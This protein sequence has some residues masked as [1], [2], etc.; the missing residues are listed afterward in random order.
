MASATGEGAP[1]GRILSPKEV[2]DRIPQQEPFRFIDEIIEID[3]DHCSASYRWREDAAF[4]RGHF[5]GDPVTPGV[6]LVEALAQASVVAMTA[7][8]ENR[9]NGKCTQTS[10]VRAS[11]VASTAVRARGEGGVSHFRH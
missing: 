6:L 5:P 9:R 11:P 3:G 1:V 2:L 4:Y 8:R 10:G 7:T